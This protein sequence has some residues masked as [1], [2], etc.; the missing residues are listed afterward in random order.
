M[1]FAGLLTGCAGSGSDKRIV[2][3]GHNQSTNHP[4]HIALEAF[5]DYINEELGDKYVVEVYPSELLGSQT[6]MVQLTQTGAID[7]C[8][9]S[10]AILETFSKNYSIFNLPYLFSS[11]EAYHAAM[12]D[13]EVTDPIFLATAEAGFTAVTWLDAGTRNFYTVDK[14]INAPEDLKGLKIRVQQSPTNI[15]MMDALGGSATP[16]GFGEVYTA[17]QSNIIDGAE[18]NEMALTDNGH[19]DVCKY[20]SYDMHQMVPDILIGN[21]AFVEGLPE[22]ERAIFEEGFELV[23]SVQREEW[24]K[25]VENAKEKAANDQGVEFIYPDT[26][27]FQEACMPIHESVITGNEVLEKIYA[28]IQDYNAQYAKAE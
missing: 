5:A 13:P 18:N 16:M 26:A 21:L 10:N 25:A 11:A 27:P 12:E 7:F 23:N 22:D 15:A 14:P 19:G 2:R 6:E 9:A 28:M 8:I 4:S 20:Y 1:L 17:L 3:I 24:T